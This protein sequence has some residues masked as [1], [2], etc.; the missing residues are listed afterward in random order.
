MSWQEDAVELF[1]DVA[2][3]EFQ[4]LATFTI[5]TTNSKYN[6]VTGSH[7]EPADAEWPVYLFEQSH[8]DNDSPFD[9]S[10]VSGQFYAFGLDEDKPEGLTNGLTVE[11][12]GYE[13]KIVDIVPDHLGIMTHLG[14]DPL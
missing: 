6:P 5:E 12:G 10:P 7:G 8:R 4:Q 1:N 14:L 3:V 13:Y 9:V 2:F 11:I